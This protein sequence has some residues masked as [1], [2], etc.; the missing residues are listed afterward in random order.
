M[1]ALAAQ[2]KWKDEIKTAK[3]V[4]VTPPPMPPAAVELKE[5]TKV[6][7]WISDI[8]TEKVARL[9][10]ENVDGLV[11]FRDEIAG[12]FGSFDKYG[13][14]GADKS[15]WLEV[16]GGRPHRYDRVGLGNDSIDIPFSAVTLLGCIQPD[17]LNTMI[18]SGDDDGLA[19][20]PIYAWPDAVRPKVP[21]ARVDRDILL[22]VLRRLRSLAFDADMDGN[23]QARVKPLS[24]DAFQEFAAWWQGRQWDAKRGAG[25]RIA[26]AI[27]KLD[28]MALRLAQVFELLEWAWSGSNQPEPEEI[29]LKSVEKALRLI[30]TWMRA[31]LERVFAEASF[32]KVQRDAAVVGRWLLKTKPKMVNA[33]DLRRQP[34]FPGPKDAKELET[35][36]EFLVDAR[37]L[38]PPATTNTPGQPGR[39][40]KDYLVNP[41]IYEESREC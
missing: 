36:L 34:G 27:G 14:A 25:G 11:N 19:A 37:W 24:A 9:L 22:T 35:V 5:P 13:G 33:R 26:G 32:P 40:R 8:T 3:K 20:R 4:G 41:A 30:D 6:R 29:G 16:Y 15:F 31:T 39:P 23:P 2:E 10:G 28:G 7:V 21:A 1:D 38:S 18:L 12:L 17:R